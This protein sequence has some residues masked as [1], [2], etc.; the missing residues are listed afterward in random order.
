M[1]DV[2]PTKL[3]GAPQNH[4][5]I[6]RVTRILEEVVYNPGMTFVE[7]VRALDAPK[8][9]VH[10]FIQG[11]LAA[12]WLYQE[13]NRFFLGPALYGMTLAS[14]SFRAGM[15]TDSDVATL[16]GAA[17]VT[18]FLGVQAGDHLIY[19]SEFGADRLAGFA[20]RSNIRRTMLGTAG[21]KAILAALPAIQRDAFLRRRRPEEAA[22]VDQF[23]VEY[24]D[25]RRTRIAW[26]TLHGGTRSA[27]ATVVT[28]SS[29][30]P[31]AEV[32]LVGPS[33]EILPREE[34]LAKLLLE[35]VDSWQRRSPLTRGTSGQ[36]SGLTR[37]RKSG[38]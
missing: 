37:S 15:V 18:V 16:Y 12:G 31:V 29:G 23:L 14:G 13:E 9:S 3:D 17:G 38:K 6:D 20:A 4:R 8:S 21:G 33:A 2:P 1:T 25:I 35:H 36:G 10:G 32:T 28:G 11:L 7:L 24:E 26:N 30:E 22:A 27:L 19:V 5:T 34:E